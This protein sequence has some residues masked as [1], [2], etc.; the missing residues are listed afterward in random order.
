MKFGLIPKLLL[1]LGVGIIIGFYGPDWMIRFT[2]T[3]NMLLG[4]LIKF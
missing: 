1:G 2:E 3:G 4:N